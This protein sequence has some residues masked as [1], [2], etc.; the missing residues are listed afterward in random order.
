MVRD[1]DVGEYEYCVSLFVYG[2]QF[3]CFWCIGIN[4]QLVVFNCKFMVVSIRGFEFDCNM[5]VKLMYF[6]LSIFC[7]IGCDI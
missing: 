7:L 4:G 3:V 2:S 6:F 5:L 1:V